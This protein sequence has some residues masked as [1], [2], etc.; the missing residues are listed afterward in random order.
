MYVF[1]NGFKRD[2]F[3]DVRLNLLNSW[4]YLMGD[5]VTVDTD[6]G[7]TTKCVSDSSAGLWDCGISGSQRDCGVSGSR[8]G[9]RMLTPSLSFQSNVL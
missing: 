5:R 1:G 4:L 6:H 2:V 7:K 3:L 9:W 8:A